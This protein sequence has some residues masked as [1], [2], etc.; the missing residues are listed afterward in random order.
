G[1]RHALRKGDGRISAEGSVEEILA[2]GLLD[3]VTFESEELKTSV[4]DV[5]V[6]PTRKF[7]RAT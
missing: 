2:T 1:A 6:I 3:D 7:Q 4:E 5:I